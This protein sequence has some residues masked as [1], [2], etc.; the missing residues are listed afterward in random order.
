MNKPLENVE[1]LY[2]TFIN[3]QNEKDFFI[4]FADY[5]SYLEN[6]AELLACFISEIEKGNELNAVLKNAETLAI[7][8]FKETL[9]KAKK[10]TKKNGLDKRPYIIEL[11]KDIDDH[12]T[13]KVA[14]SA[15]LLNNVYNDLV[16]IVSVLVKEKKLDDVRKY[17]KL[18]EQWELLSQ[19][20]TKNCKRLQTNYNYC[21]LNTKNTQRQ[22]TTIKPQ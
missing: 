20:M 3:K 17:A 4:G 13:K 16:D 1:R 9:E 10:D 8:E 11:Y 5:F 6:N 18:Y 12:F 2:N 15:P 19:I 22:T 14:S 21:V 7:N